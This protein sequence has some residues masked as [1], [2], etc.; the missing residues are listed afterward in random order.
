MKKLFLTGALLASAAA[1]TYAATI[2]IEVDGD[3]VSGSVGPNSVS[4]TCAPGGC[5]AVITIQTAMQ[6]PQVGDRTVFQQTE[7]TPENVIHQW[8]GYY[9][10]HQVNKTPVGNDAR[11]DFLNPPHQDF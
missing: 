9:L 2:R 1:A 4:V 5:C 8:S 7:G 10:N 6:A 3:F 11:V